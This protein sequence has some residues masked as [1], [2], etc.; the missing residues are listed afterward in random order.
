MFRLPQSV[1]TRLCALEASAARENRIDV[2]LQDDYTLII[3]PDAENE[4]NKRIYNPS[5]TFKKFH[6][7]KNFA[8][9]IVGCY[10]SGK[11]TGCLIDAVINTILMPPCLDGV[12]RARVLVVR[13][14]FPELES[15][16]IPTWNNWFADMGDIKKRMKAPITFIHN[17]NDKNG[18]IELH[19]LFL[20]L[21]RPSDIQKLKSF[22]STFAILEEASELDREVFNHAKARIGRWPSEQ[23]C[24]EK[25]DKKI[26]LPTNPPDESHWIY[27]IFEV[28]K[29]DKH[30]I[31]KQPPA[32]LWKEN[33][34][35]ENPAAE[36][37]ENLKDGYGY[38]FDASLGQS[39]E[40]IKVFIEGK[41]GVLR[42]GQV[43]FP[44]Y[45]DD[46]HS[47]EDIKID[48]D[49]PIVMTADYGT[50]CPALVVGQ[51]VYGQLRIIKEFWGMFLTM[52]ELY[53]LEASP[54]LIQNAENFK[55]EDLIVVGDPAKTYG[56][57]KDLEE[58][59]LRVIDAP[60]NR[61][62]RRISAVVT[63]LTTINASGQ[64]CF[65]LSR[66][67]CP[68]ARAGFM[69]DYKY[70]ELKTGQG[71]VYKDNPKKDHPVS[72]LHDGIQYHALRVAD[73]NIDTL[74]KTDYNQYMSQSASVL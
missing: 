69:R 5:P 19:V 40:F 24:T 10:G 21:N 17:F 49:F 16:T 60:T 26:I 11:T 61:I 7:D 68:K 25:F 41:Y 74:Q 55:P 51:Y 14:T 27:D 44:Q 71:I 28:Q 22:E 15:T 58:C 63:L 53:Q 3:N 37:I 48:N 70:E 50:V 30:S 62:D 39:K 52:K 57:N 1:E 31:Y 56:G 72:D 20:A 73:R 23:I 65:C 42:S 2:E 47:V 66:K 29:P 45:N 59:G 43:V 12:R 4:E 13:N 38:Y 34:L 32:L 9:I 35:V 8:R 67:G 33:K 46:L 54:W 6:A 18:E 36:N 64:M